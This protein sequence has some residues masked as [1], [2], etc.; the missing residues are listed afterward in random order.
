M[1]IL[2]YRGDNVINDI[3]IDPDVF[4]D[5]GLLKTDPVKIKLKPE[6]VPYHVS[7]ARRIALP[8]VPLVEKELKRM[9]MNGVISKVTKPTEWCAPIVATMKKTGDVRLC[10]DLRKLNQCVERETFI[11]PA[12][13]DI[14]S[15]LSGSVKYSTLDASGAYWQLP[16][17]EESKNLTTF[18]TPQGRY[19]FNRLPYGITSASEIYQR[20]MYEILGNLDGVAVYQDDVI[21]YGK[22]DEEHDV[23][24][25]K[26]IQVIKESG[27]KLSKKKSKIGQRSL[28]FLGHHISQD[29]VR[30]DPE[31][32]QTI[33]DL[34]PPNDIHSLRRFCGMVNHLGQYLPDLSKVMKP[35]NDL[36]K[37][38]LSLVGV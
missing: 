23:R 20:K 26:V 24:L 6:S 13:E 10:V 28:K 22:T 34:E 2:E 33:M 32:I 3:N 17:S 1:N 18:I 36:R 15:K 16:L 21:I 19:Q 7:V 11:I 31:K 14:I 5:I 8:L 4:Q 12:I 38:M 9:E 29:E 30:A 27:L 37:R 35:I 25:I